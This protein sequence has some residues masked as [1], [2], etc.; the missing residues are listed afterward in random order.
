MAVG[1]NLI[2]RIETIEMRNVTM[3]VGWVVEVAEPLLQL[4]LLT[5]LHRRQL[6]QRVLEAFYV[7][8]VAVEQLSGFDNRG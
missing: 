2:A 8:L 3:V 6:R 5:N 1:R 4:S 7:C